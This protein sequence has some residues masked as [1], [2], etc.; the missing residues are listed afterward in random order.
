VANMN[1]DPNR[2]GLHAMGEKAK[3][4]AA[5]SRCGPPALC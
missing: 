5:I 3:L 1:V 4:W 2:W